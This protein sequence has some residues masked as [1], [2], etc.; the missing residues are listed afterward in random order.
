MKSLRFNI[1]VALLV[2]AICLAGS[3]MAAEIKFGVQ[4]SRGAVKALK[5]WTEMAKYL[6][7]ET[8]YKIKL[9]PLNPSVT[10]KAAK[11]GKVDMMLSNPVLA[12]VLQ[13]KMGFTPVATLKKKSGPRFGGVIISKKGSGIKTAKDLKGKKV[14]A[15][16]FK[17]SAAAYVFQV[18]HLKDKGID[19]HKDF[20]S[21]KE[22]KKQDD[23]VLAVHKGL[24]DAGFVKTGMVEAMAKEGKI[25]L[26]EINIVDQVKD[27]YQHKH[28]TALYPHWTLGYKPG[29]DMAIVAKVKAAL[30]KLKA[31][32]VAAKKAKIKGFVEAVSLDGLSETLKALKLPPYDS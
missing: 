22:A 23:I 14:M 16:K 12:V 17:K 32:H 1:L 19:P 31:D 20:K 21:F 25:K 11:E 10:V 3:A 29:Y 4:A 6:E 27:D 8:G 9:V 7:K 30:L 15:Y 13:K 2:S 24:I 5:K 18:K 26:D 28:T